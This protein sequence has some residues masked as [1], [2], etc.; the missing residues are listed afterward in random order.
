MLMK[1]GKTTFKAG[2]VFVLMALAALAACSTDGGGDTEAGENGKKEKPEPVPVVRDNPKL[3]A[4][5]RSIGVE[6]TAISGLTEYTV[7]WSEPEDEEERGSK[8]ISGDASDAEILKT[9]ISGLENA[10]PYWVWVKAGPMTIGKKTCTPAGK[11]WYVGNTGDDANDGLSNASPL[12]TITAALTKIADDV[13]DKSAEIVILSDLNED[14]TIDH[15][16]V[17]YPPILLRGD[18]NPVTITGNLTITDDNADSPEVS[19]GA[20][21]TLSDVGDV[22]VTVQGGSLTM[23]NG[24]AI[25]G[26]SRTGVDVTNAGVFTMTGGEITNNSNGVGVSSVFTM[27][28]GKITNNRT[29]GVVVEAGG[30]FLMS[31]G[32]AIA[33]NRTN[34]VS[35]KAG[36]IFNMTGGTVGVFPK[37]DGGGN[38]GYGVFVNVGGTFRMSNGR[39]WSNNTGVGIN[40]GMFN[41]TGGEIGANQDM[42]V[43]WNGTP[44]IEKRGGIVYGTDGGANANSGGSFNRDSMTYLKSQEKKVPQN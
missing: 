15:R 14:V 26:G 4:G 2:I 9:T 11:I 35:V 21:L 32:A 17:D 18:G 16:S 27:T 38:G 42:G 25:T 44:D 36:G 8:E 33:N 34:G 13:G 41:M 5:D 22:V 23:R 7:Y 43:F 20:N 30:E 12:P 1:S 37:E 6:W 28:G 40:S 3:T 39:V 24:A 10:I 31:D 19:L 29:D